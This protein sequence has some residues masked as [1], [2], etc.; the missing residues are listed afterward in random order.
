MRK[1]KVK[2]L[3]ILASFLLILAV[4]VL[5]LLSRPP[6]LIVA[7]Q[8]F[9]SLYSPLRIKKEALASSLILFRLVKPVIIADDA[10][11]DIILISTANISKH[12]FCVIFPI[13]FAKAAKLYRGQNPEIPVIILEGR[14]P[15]DA[16]PASS[17]IETAADFFCYKTDVA[18]DYYCAGV[19]A[20]VIDEEKN[21]AV[22]V[23]MDHEIQKQAREAFLKALQDREKTIKPH[24]YTTFSQ[25][26]LNRLSDI[27]CGVVAGNGVE[28]MENFPQV[29]VILFSWMD[30]SMIPANVVIVFNDSPMIQA[31]PAVRMA[32]AGIEKGQIPTKPLVL[33]E[34]REGRELLRKLNK[35]LKMTKDD[36]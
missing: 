35:N 8:S 29:P 28:F 6:V 36:I 27:S 31:V 30:F 14:S 7:D 24:F 33:K 10:G 22:V 11:E 15:A 23:F 12:P 20:A 17:A 32:A 1:N 13:R 21:G 34:N 2:C 9:V 18:A 19:A 5:I 3:I 25:N 16:K 4:P 26:Q